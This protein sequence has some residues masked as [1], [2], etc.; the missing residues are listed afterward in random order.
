[1]SE[2][3]NNEIVKAVAGLLSI[4]TIIILLLGGMIL[5][6]KDDIQM[7]IV[8]GLIGFLARDVVSNE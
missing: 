4:N 8:A 3:K 7:Q 6:F 1:M 5:F 2:I